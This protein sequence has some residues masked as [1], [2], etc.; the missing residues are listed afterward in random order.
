MFRSS[1]KIP[2]QN[3][4]LEFYVIQ[5]ARTDKREADQKDIGLRVGEG[6]KSVVVL[7][8]GCIPQSNINWPWVHHDVGGVVIKYGWDVL[9]RKSVSSVADE[10]AGLSNCPISHNHTLNGQHD[11]TRESVVSSWLGD[12]LYLLAAV[13][14][15]VRSVPVWFNFAWPRRSVLVPEV[16]WNVPTGLVTGYYTH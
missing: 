11:G 5:W 6:P 3:S 2:S 7:L 4:H 8:A 9:S 16:A 12:V 15:S 13:P 14:C 1:A 10:Q